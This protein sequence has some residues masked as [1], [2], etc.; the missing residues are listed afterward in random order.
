MKLFK[1]TI[2]VIFFI[3]LI[4]FLSVVA[5]EFTP[6]GNINGRGVYGIYN[7]TTINGTILYQNGNQVI[8]SSSI[9]NQSSNYSSFANSSTYWD[10]ETSQSNL[11]VNSSDY[12]DNLTNQSQLVITESQISD[13]THTTDTNTQKGTSGIFLYNDSTNIFFNDTLLNDTIDARDS[14]TIYTNGTD[15]SLVGTTFSL[16][17]GVYLKVVDFFTKATGT[18]GYLYNDSTTIYFN[19]T[20]LNDTIDDRDA[21]TT[22]TAGAGLNLAATTFSHNDSSSQGSSDNSGRTYIQD[23]TLDTYGHLT[24][25][26]TATETVVDT[27]IGNCSVTNSC[28]NIAYDVEINKSY[29]DTQ[30]ITF[31]DSMKTYVDNTFITQANEGNLNVNS[32]DY[33]DNLNSPSDINA[34]DITDDNTYVI[35]SGDTMTGALNMSTNPIYLNGITL[36][37]LDQKN[38]NIA[39]PAFGMYMTGP[40][41]QNLPHLI[42]SSGGPTQATT[43]LR[44]MMIVNEIAG[45]HNTTNATDCTAYMNEIGET[46]KIDCNTTTTGADL[47][48][49]DD[50]QVVGDLWNKDTDGDWHFLTRTLTELDN[51]YDD[52]L[53]NRLDMDVTGTNLSFNTTLGDTI[54]VNLNTSETITTI[55]SDSITL[56]AGTNLTPVRNIITYQT[57]GN[58]SLVSSTTTPTADH[59]NVADVMLG[60]AGN[61]Y[62]AIFDGTNNYEFIKKVYERFLDEGAI[63]KTGFSIGGSAT[64]L[65]I[66]SGTLKSQLQSVT[67]SLNLS[68]QTDGF[69]WIEANGNFMQSTTLDVFTNYSDGTPITALKFYNVVY[70]VVPI[71]DS[72]ARI[73]AVVQDY[74]SDKPEYGK[75]KDAEVDKENKVL[76][77]PSNSFL[78]NIFIPV[79]RVIYKKGTASNQ[80]LSNGNYF[81]DVRGQTGISGGSPPAPSITDHGNLDGLADDDHTLYLLANG[82][83]ALTG[84][85]DVG[86]FDIT[87]QAINA[88]DWTNVTILES[89]VTDLVHTT[90]TNAST[91]CSGGQVLFGNGTCGI[92]I[93]TDTTYTAGT[94]LS[95]GGGAFSWDTTYGDARYYTQST[96]D[97]TFITQANEGNLNVNHSD[98][99]TDWAG[100]TSFQTKWLSDS[101]NVLTFDEAEL[102]TSIEAYGYSTTTGTVT[103]VTG[104]APITSTGGTTPEIGIT[105]AKDLVTTAPLTGGTN[106]IL[107]GSDSDI[108]IAIPVAT[109]IADGYLSQTDWSTF[110]NKQ[111]ALTF[112]IA[113]GNAVDID[114][115]TVASGEYAKFTA[116]GLESKS[117]AE[118]RADLDLEAGTDFYSKT[119]EDTWRNSVTQTEMGYLNGVSSDIQTQLNTKG[120]M[121]D[122]IDDTTPQLG[123]NLDTNGNNI[124]G[125][126]NQLFIRFGNNICIFTNSTGLILYNNVSGV[127]C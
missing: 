81:F 33:W 20:K 99:A 43:L 59:A 67:T 23:I 25:L 119:A 126:N 78:K 104:A 28:S 118:V 7:F 122:L 71:S 85:W 2:N 24:G 52:I 31:N 120:D 47:L 45:F 64:Q 22:Y 17:Q 125:T 92:A 91:A 61:I 35:V 94:G 113:N 107:T 73:M 16:I 14:S 11:N 54:I 96:A 97:S 36:K 121:N 106:N 21:D 30:D 84:N 6:Q 80:L 58:P 100:V 117:F 83:R 110:N 5:V 50:L 89:Q 38:P 101:A 127:D 90:D 74:P 41:G 108:T 69:F 19:E 12:W 98:F 86:N 76:L 123:G 93:D 27:T 82:T 60:T 57:A 111:S 9:T 102:N 29:V 79:A 68:I 95:L 40:S 32:S 105:V 77:F 112:G 39:G 13:L 115:S 109:S 124:T 8:D 37:P 70:G 63:Y 49:G 44:S 116:N 1:K 56:T 26:A 72:E 15:I 65:N 66:S 87:L 114:S 42:L 4:S 53:F 46:L 48:V 75:L 55:T 88:D 103:A 10:G 3:F 51:L 62:G 18:S 34:G